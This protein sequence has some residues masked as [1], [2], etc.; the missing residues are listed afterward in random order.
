MPVHKVSLSL[1]SAQVCDDREGVGVPRP[2]CILRHRDSYI[3]AQHRTHVTFA[4]CKTEDIS[5]LQSMAQGRTM[6]SFDLEKDD[7]DLG[8]SIVR[9]EISGVNGIFIKDIQPDS[10]AYSSGYLRVGDQILAVNDKLL[11][12]SVTQAEAEQ[13]LLEVVSEVTFTVARDL[14][15]SFSPP[16]P[17]Q[18]YHIVL[19]NDGSGLGFGIVGGRSTGT[20]VKTILPE[21]VAR[22]DGRLRSGDLLLRIGDVDVS[23]MG[24]EEVA[25]ELRFAGAIVR[26]VIARETTESSSAWQ[27]EPQRNQ[28]VPEQNE[29]ECRVRFTCCKSVEITDKGSGGFEGKSILKGNPVDHDRQTQRGHHLSAC[30]KGFWS[31]G[32]I[33]PVV[34]G[35]AAET[36]KL[37]FS[38]QSSESVCEGV[39]D[40]H[41][42]QVSNQMGPRRSKGLLP[43]YTIIPTCVSRV[44]WG[45]RESAGS[46]GVDGQIDQDCSKQKADAMLHTTGQQVELSFLKKSSPSAAKT[47]PISQRPLTPLGLLPPPLPPCLPEPKPVLPPGK[48]FYAERRDFNFNRES[49]CRLSE[50]EEK[51]LK[52]KWQSALGPRSEVIVA[53]V[54]KFIESSGL[55]VSLESQDGHHYICSMLPEGPMGRAGIIHPGD[56]LLEVNGFSLLGEAH[57][58]VVS[59]L[60]ELPVNVCVVC[61]RVVPPAD[62]GNDHDGDVQLTLK[63]LLEEFNDKQEF[64]VMEP[65]VLSHQAMWEKKIQVY[66]LQKDESGLGFSILDYQ[67]PMNPGLTVIVIRSLVAGGLAERDGHLL[68]GDRLMFVNETDLSHASLAQAVQVLK[69]TALGI[70]RIGVAKPLAENDIQERGAEIRGHDSEENNEASALQKNLHSQSGEMEAE[71]KAIPMFSSGYERTITI[72]RGNSSLGMFS[73]FLMLLL[74][75]FLYILSLFHR[76]VD[77]VRDL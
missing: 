8:I 1:I 56:Q 74:C 57:K 27:L 41:S 34:F 44:K 52:E 48:V 53:R 55:G 7:E 22:K 43:P 33:S 51:A 3:S 71:A 75:V 10:V 2:P 25:Q 42:D 24:S 13:I 72:V 69:S 14:T 32:K 54:E 17:R 49:Y 20:M 63:E 40:D 29:K 11:D 19:E 36:L 45:F 59:L 26:L 38:L 18:I 21:G 28:D 5:L 68:P 60:K 67:D 76:D 31:C 65:P 9:L 64:P 30:S 12:S 62:S 4:P 47:S 61:S 35:G 6:L 37:L 39:N 77:S 46:R 58:E 50:E 70:V 15:P 66:E 73:L 23:A 16:K